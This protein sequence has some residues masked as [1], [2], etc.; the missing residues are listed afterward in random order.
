MLE[1]VTHQQQQRENSGDLVNSKLTNIYVSQQNY[2]RNIP[3]WT[4]FMLGPNIR[5]KLMH[6]GK[7]S[8]G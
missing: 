4:P 6:F 8:P 5:P 3:K 7:E 2:L 1:S